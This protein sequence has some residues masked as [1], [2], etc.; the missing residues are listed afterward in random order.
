MDVSRGDRGL[1][2]RYRPASPG[3]EPIEQR[4]DDRHQ[5]EGDRGRKEDA[6]HD[7]VA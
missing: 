4:V 2:H 7:G 5:E 1:L 3:Q 6:A